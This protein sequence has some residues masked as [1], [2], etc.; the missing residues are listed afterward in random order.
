MWLVGL[1]LF[2]GSG[3]RGCLGLVRGRLLLL[4]FGFL[5][6]IGL[7]VMLRWNT[8][9]MDT[10][11][12]GSRHIHTYM[13]ALLEYFFELHAYPLLYIDLLFLC[14]WFTSSLRN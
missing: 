10:G 11:Y 3:G 5:V 1:R 6:C 13:R 2:V 8:G 9:R 4:D 12:L 14:S 7:L